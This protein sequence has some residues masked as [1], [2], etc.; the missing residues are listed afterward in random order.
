MKKIFAA[1]FVVALSLAAGGVYAL[2]VFDITYP[3]AE[4]GGCADRVACKAYCDDAANADACFSFAQ[5]Y[6][7]QTT[8]QAATPAAPNGAQAALGGGETAAGPENLPPVG[9]GGCKGIDECKT[10]CSDPSHADECFQFGK[11]HGLISADQAQQFQQQN[12]IA[13][14][15]KQGGGPG[16]CT[17]PDAC[18]T[19][20]SDPAHLDE[21]VAFGEK[22][23]LLSADQ[24]A[25]MKQQGF[26]AVMDEQQQG[27]FQGPGGCKSNDECKTYCNDPAN[28]DT[29]INCAVDHGFMTKAEAD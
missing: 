27:N 17:T 10:Y 28:Q 18:K 3:I 16:G 29:C 26:K 22:N 5:K 6:G 24:A 9:P 20:C 21:C 12:K 13:D 14:V 11:A 4:L 1:G 2:S 25:Q 7:I 15:L 23:G 8:V 19:Y